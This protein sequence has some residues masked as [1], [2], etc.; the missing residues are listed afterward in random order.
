MQIN[1][2]SKCVS[3]ANYHCSKDSG[4]LLIKLSTSFIMKFSLQEII[5]AK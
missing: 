3:G 1:F 5:H 2:G 4:W